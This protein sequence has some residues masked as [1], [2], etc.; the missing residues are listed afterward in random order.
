M[1]PLAQCR[2]SNV[3]LDINSN[4]KKTTKKEKTLISGKCIAP[5]TIDIVVNLTF[6]IAII[7]THFLAK[8]VSALDNELW[9]YFL[10]KTQT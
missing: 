4:N 5:K 7:I 3:A 8:F 6:K 2:S 9:V 1:C 10:Q